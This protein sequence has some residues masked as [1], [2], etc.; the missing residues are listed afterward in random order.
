MLV[1]NQAFLATGPRLKPSVKYWSVA[2]SLLWLD[3]CGGFPPVGESGENHARKNS[4]SH[5][6]SDQPFGRVKNG[7]PF[8]HK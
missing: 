5:R 4:G 1:K 3:S 7:P 6:N 8:V 2:G